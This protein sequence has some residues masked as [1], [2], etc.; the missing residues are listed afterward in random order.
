MKRKYMLVALA[1]IGIVSCCISVGASNIEDLGTMN[2]DDGYEFTLYVN[3]NSSQE[4]DLQFITSEM[5]ESSIEVINNGFYPT[6]NKT[7]YRFVAKKI[8][9]DFWFTPE[10]KDFFFIDDTTKQVYKL[11]V[12][13]SGTDVP[14]NPYKLL[15]E[16]MEEDYNWT[17]QEL[18]NISIHLTNIT[19]RYNQTKT[20]LDAKI[21]ELTDLQD[22]FDTNEVEW[23]K[24][25]GEVENL[26]NELA[27][28]Q[29]EYN[30]TYALFISVS[31]NASTYKMNWDNAIYENEQLKNENG[32]FPIYL[33]FAFGSAI[34]IV[35]LY[36]R[37]KKLF[38]H[39][40]PNSIEAERD[41]GYKPQ[42]S[43]IDRFTSGIHF[44]KKT[45][46]LSEAI[47]DI[48][49][50]PNP[51]INLTEMDDMY[52]EIE[53]ITKNY[54]VT[55]QDIENLQSRMSDIEGTLGMA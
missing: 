8:T 7:L 3:I 12:N 45:E 37:R 42:A 27:N 16:D 48:K 32:M 17:S 44:S 38:K 19:E 23:N 31:T 50:K 4:V 20:E 2:Y 47:D 54:E 9:P 10:V 40:Q 29:N 39:Q 11:S 22:N 1:I 46:T 55:S 33:F 52:S 49:E 28:L 13:Y 41:S 15:Y 18:T 25:E 14:E 5:N 6:E 24:R 34:I 53:R 26:T 21:A 43:I 36:D 35:G 51:K 30:K